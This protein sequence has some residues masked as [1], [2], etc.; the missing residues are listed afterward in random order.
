[1]GFLRALAPT[2]LGHLFEGD[3]QVNGIRKCGQIAQQPN[4]LFNPCIF[5]TYGWSLG[6]LPISERRHGYLV[7][8]A[9][10]AAPFKSSFRTEAEGSFFHKI[11]TLN[12]RRNTT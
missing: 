2:L 10:R 8:R 7:A 11:T 12:N 9:A 1:M 4:G 3:F 5:E 6:V